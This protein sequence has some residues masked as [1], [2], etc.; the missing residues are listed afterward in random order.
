VVGGWDC[1]APLC[2]SIVLCHARWLAEF[3][4]FRC[5]EEEEEDDDEE[6]ASS[7]GREPE[8]EE[9]RWAHAEAQSWFNPVV[10]CWLIMLFTV[11]V[12]RSGSNQESRGCSPGCRRI[13]SKRG[14]LHGVVPTTHGNEVMMMVCGFKFSQSMSSSGT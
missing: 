6:E 2:R 7:S 5:R 4:C 12:A 3:R 11:V 1:C 10:L 13:G 14:H 8:T 9:T